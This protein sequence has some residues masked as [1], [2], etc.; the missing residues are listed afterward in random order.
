MKASIKLE[1]KEFPITF[2]RNP[3]VQIIALE[4]SV[5]QHKGKWLPIEIKF[6][7]IEDEQ[8][9]IAFSPKNVVLNRI[10]DEKIFCSWQLFDITSI[11]RKDGLVIIDFEGCSLLN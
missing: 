9:F 6:D 4:S 10:V 3:S 1:D 2:E 8:D 5:Q 11:S 7:E